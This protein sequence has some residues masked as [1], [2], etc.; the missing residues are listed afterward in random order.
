MAQHDRHFKR[1]ESKAF[2]NHIT[3]T[4]EYIRKTYCHII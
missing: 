3:M 1:T 4:T 2:C